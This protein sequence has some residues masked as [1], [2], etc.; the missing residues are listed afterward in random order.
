[1]TKLGLFP[2]NPIRTAQIDMLVSDT[3]NMDGCVSREQAQRL[4]RAV[5]EMPSEP[6][7]LFVIV[8]TRSIVDPDEPPR[9]D[10]INFHSDRARQWLAKHS[11]WSLHNGYSITTAP[12]DER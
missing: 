7:P 1:M 5:H 12:D 10:K 11:W 6:A 4:A 8:V 9:R 2:A 3:I